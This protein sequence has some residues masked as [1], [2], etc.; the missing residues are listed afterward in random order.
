MLRIPY[1]RATVFVVGLGFLMQITGINAVIY[2]SP[3]IFKEIG[4]TGNCR[5]CSCRRS[6][7]SARCSR[8]SSRCRSSTA[9]GG[10]RRCSPASA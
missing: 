6:C 9:S 8:R 7:R 4:F 10:A 5:C 3:L 1:L 2:Y